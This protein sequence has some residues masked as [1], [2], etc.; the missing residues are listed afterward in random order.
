MLQLVA[1]EEF[2]IRCSPEIAGCRGLRDRMDLGSCT[3]PTVN[4]G[5]GEAVPVLFIFVV[6]PAV[7]FPDAPEKCGL[8][9][10]ARVG[11]VMRPLVQQGGKRSGSHKHQNKR[12]VPS[13]DYARNGCEQDQRD[14]YCGQ[15]QEDEWKKRGVRMVE[16][17]L[18][19]KIQFIGAASDPK[20][21]KMQQHPVHPPFL[22]WPI[23]EDPS[24]SPPFPPR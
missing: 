17:V 15:G 13:A 1:G 5:N 7:L 8:R 23:Q 19:C 6:V 4:L 14:H 18:L 3:H 12:W 11:E 22:K 24:D 16:S 20:G 2:T 9:E 21:R 10:I